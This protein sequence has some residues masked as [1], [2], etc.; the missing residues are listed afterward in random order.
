MVGTSNQSVPEMAIE[1]AAAHVFPSDGPIL[2]IIGLSLM[3]PLADLDGSEGA[4][5]LTRPYFL[6]YLWWENKSL[7]QKIPAWLY[8]IFEPNKWKNTQFSPVCQWFNAVHCWFYTSL[9][10]DAVIPPRHWLNIP[11]DLL[12]QSA[13]ISRTAINPSKNW[14]IGKLTGNPNQFAGIECKNWQHIFMHFLPTNPLHWR[15]IPL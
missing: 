15:F 9:L 12:V 4:T 14:F 6:G 1:F 5:T 13:S 8:H 3:G 2:L 11:I 10:I 7:I